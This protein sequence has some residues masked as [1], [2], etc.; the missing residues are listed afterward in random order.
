VAEGGQ[1]MSVVDALRQVPRIANDGGRGVPSLPMIDGG[2][3]DGC[4]GSQT[5]AAQTGAPD[6]A[7][8]VAVIVGGEALQGLG[9]RRWGRTE[10]N[11]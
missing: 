10:G 6:R 5:K 8:V 3:R 7:T 4:H 9:R 11:A 1:R 2:S